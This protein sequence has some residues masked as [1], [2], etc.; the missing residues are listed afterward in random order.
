MGRVRAVKF[1]ELLNSPLR[2]SGQCQDQFQ[3]HLTKRRLR[4]V[5]RWSG[6]LL[7][8]AV[9]EGPHVGVAGRFL[10][11]LGL[12]LGRPQNDLTVYRERLQDDVGALAV[13]VHERGTD[14]EPKIVLGSFFS[15]AL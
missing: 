3:V 2:R 7:L 6:F 12:G 14:V 15:L 9:L 11:R 8:A 10:R 1:K 4:C 5:A 13:L